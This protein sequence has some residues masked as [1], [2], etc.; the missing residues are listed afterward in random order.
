LGGL[1]GVTSGP[2]SRREENK[3]HTFLEQTA[4]RKGVFSAA[5]VKGAKEEPN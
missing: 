5:N 4:S 1:R 3:G 2:G